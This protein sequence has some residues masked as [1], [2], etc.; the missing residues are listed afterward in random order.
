LGLHIDTF[1]VGLC[2]EMGL[3]M[4]CTENKYKNFTKK[5]I[6]KKIQKI[7]REIYFQFFLAIVVPQPIWVMPAVLGGDRDC[8]NSSKPKTQ[9]YI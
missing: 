4:L 6:Q 9:I 3:N 1:L 8:T 7:F 2:A 5:K